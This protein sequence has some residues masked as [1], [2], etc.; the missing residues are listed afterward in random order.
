MGIGFHKDAIF[1]WQIGGINIQNSDKPSVYDNYCPP[2]QII[3][4][5]K[6]LVKHDNYHKFKLS[7]ND[8]GR[9]VTCGAKESHPGFGLSDPLI[10]SDEKRISIRWPPKRPPTFFTATEYK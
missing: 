5:N 4:C 2:G 10:L 6:T 8:D 3:P 9:T 7:Q 1:N